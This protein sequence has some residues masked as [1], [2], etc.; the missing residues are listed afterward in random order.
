VIEVPPRELARRDAARRG[1]QQAQDSRRQ[2]PRTFEDVVVQDFVKKDREIEDRESLHERQRDPNQ[3]VLETDESPRRKAEDRKLTDPHNEVT[4]G[5]FLMER[6]Q[7]I[8]GQ[9]LRQIGLERHRMPGVVVGFHADFDSS[10]GGYGSHGSEG[11][12]CGADRVNATP[13]RTAAAPSISG[14]VR[15]SSR[16]STAVTIATIGITLE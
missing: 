8:S 11:R 6:A 7:L 15:V 1:V 3:G 14:T 2:R 9:G 5:G 13:V 12:D 4:N 10:T 16:K